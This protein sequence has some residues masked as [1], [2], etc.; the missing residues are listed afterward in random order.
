MIKLF[1]TGDIH[2]GKKYDRYPEVKEELIRSRFACLERCV[3]EAERQHCDF[4]V[5]TGDLFDNNRSISQRDVRQVA[6]ILSRFDGR[7][8]VLPGNHDFYTGEEKLWKDFQSALN[9]REHSVRLITAFETLRFDDVGEESISFYPAFCQSK[10]SPENNLAWIQNTEMDDAD[11]HIGLAHGALKG[12]TPDLKNEYF[13]MTEKELLAIPVDAWLI[14][15]THIPYPD[16]LSERTDKAGYTIFNPGTPEQTDLSNNT[17][18]LCFIVSLERSEGQTLVS[19]HFYRSGDI[20]YYDISATVGESGLEQ[21][22]SS[23]TQGL[24]ARSV[25][26]LTI[27]GAVPEEQYAGK[28]RIYDETLG[29]FLTYEVDDAELSEQITPE[30]IRAEFAEIGFAARFLEKLTD[31][32]EVQMAYELIKQHQA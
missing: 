15:H 17:D 21:T 4:F 23:V 3:K 25:V 22:I 32:R 5:I 10:H 18:G 14:G 7:V 12:V 6:D 11:Y 29:R 20:H 31:P 27:K 19:A 28:Q 13:L 9:G 24:Q 8:L 2:I 30:R 16:S 1:V 26:R